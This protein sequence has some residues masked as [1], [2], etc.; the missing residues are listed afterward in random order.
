MTAAGASDSGDA[1]RALVVTNADNDDA[2]AFAPLL[3]EAL[4]SRGVA[5]ARWERGNSAS[6]SA[7]RDRSTPAD[8]LVVVLGG[9]GFLMQTIRA[10]DY[11]PTPFYGVNYGQVGFLMNPR[12]DAATLAEIVVERR[13]SEVSYPMLQASIELEDGSSAEAHAVNDFVL[14]RASGQ[15]VHL[16]AWIDDVPL[17]RYSGD[18]LVFATPG[19]SSAY[20]LAAGGPVVHEGV[21]C[22]ILTPLYP[23]RPVQF[24]SLQFPIILP[25]E[26][27]VRIA[28]ESTGKRPVRLVADGQT[29][30]RVAAVEITH[31]G[32]RVRMCRFADYNFA[33]ALVRKIIGGN[34][35][36]A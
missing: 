11:P 31:G 19:G 15:T 32:K 1:P 9:D 24:H 25:L 21:D 18:G 26:G 29:V 28:A 6:H 10:L 14:E 2:R 8:S 34:S 22:M 27:R 30:E 23:H 20:S 4:E 12:M 16:R 13:F 33:D 35:R 17:N 7:A 3:I 36:E 5:V